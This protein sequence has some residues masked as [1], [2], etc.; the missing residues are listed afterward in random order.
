MNINAQQNVNKKIN[1]SA[2]IP[3]EI[4]EKILEISRS[5]ERSVS[6]V[7]T[8]LLASHPELKGKKQLALQS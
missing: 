1:I 5:E 4:K 7:I 8:R 2:K 6:Q 3:P